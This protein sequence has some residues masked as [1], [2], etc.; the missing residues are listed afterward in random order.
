MKTLKKIALGLLIL[1][2]VIAAVAQCLPDHWQVTRSVVIHAPGEAILPL[3]SD[4]KDGW[5]KWSTFD[6]EDPAITYTYSG[7]ASGV[8][9]QRAWVSK[10]M[11]NG[12]QKILQADPKTGVEFELVMTDYKMRLDG[13]ISFQG[14]SGGT[15]VT[16]TDEGQLG[17]NPM[18]R[19]MGQMMDSMMGKTFEASLGNLKTAV[20]RAAMDAKAKKP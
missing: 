17:R 14:A 2:A 1:M 20:E 10:Q 18:Q 12:T 4:L 15:Q 3:V 11:G 5:G 16:W 6:L 19:I 7:P 9:A 13:H 8:G